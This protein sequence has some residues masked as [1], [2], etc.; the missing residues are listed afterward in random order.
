[1]QQ[2][3]HDIRPFRASQSVPRRVFSFGL[4]AL[5]QI[6]F[7]Y[8]LV[9]GLASQ[10]IQ[11]LP[12]EL[13]AEVV[14]EKPPDNPKTPPPPPPDLVKPPPPFV[15][16]P[17][18][19]I[20]NEAPAT[21]AITAVTAQKPAGITAPASIGR[22]HACPSDKWYPPIAVRLGEEGTTT[23]AFKIMTDGSVAEAAVADSSGHSDLDDAALRCVSGW[24]YNPAMQ[25][26]QPVAVP[27]KTSVK[28]NLR[29]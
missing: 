15:P 27:W 13:K 18:I 2:P 21:T 20:Q 7:V 22:P 28:W 14:Q 9:T 17:D 6:V 8:T 12:D 23:V 24:R 5:I 16:P 1:M 26:G 3:Q 10:L 11:K 4:A 19:N 25:N 29:G